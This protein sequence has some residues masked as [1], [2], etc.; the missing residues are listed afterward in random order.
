VTI[1][2]FQPDI[3]LPPLKPMRVQH[4]HRHFKNGVLTR[5]VR[6][7]LREHPDDVFTVEAV[8]P[9]VIGDRQFNERDLNRLRVTV[10]QTLY[11]VERH[12]D[13]VRMESEGRT[14]RWRSISDM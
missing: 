12:G 1:R 7:Y 9:A 11:R 4:R 5:L 8:M 6:D 10:Y 14:V 2:V 13:I 3:E